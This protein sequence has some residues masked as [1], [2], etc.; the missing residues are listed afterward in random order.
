M[1]ISDPN[2]PDNNI[3]GGTHEIDLIFGC[4][5]D[6]YEILTEGLEE[7]NLK[8]GSMGSLLGDIIGG[9]YNAYYQQRDHL[10]DL[11]EKAT[12]GSSSTHLQPPLPLDQH[13]NFLP[14]NPP[15]KPKPSDNQAKQPESPAQPPKSKPVPS[16]RL[17]EEKALTS[18]PAQPTKPPYMDPDRVNSSV[19][20]TTI[21]TPEMPPTSD[22]GQPS[23]ASKISSS[24][25]LS[26]LLAKEKAANSQKITRAERRATRLRELRPDIPHVPKEINA[27]AAL[28]LGGYQNHADMNNN[29]QALEKQKG[30]TKKP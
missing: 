9:Y 7:R 8:I 16:Q 24:V 20:P 1:A 28:K 6:A 26:T 3:S 22:S 27:K 21:F 25:I 19:Q 2:Q 14:Q 29:L 30:N 12:T 17:Q 23:S 5:S 11:F 15:A 10:W 4:F 13:I 18:G